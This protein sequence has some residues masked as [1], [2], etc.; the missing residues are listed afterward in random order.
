MNMNWPKRV[1]LVRH[2]ESEGNIK[3]PNDISFNNKANHEFVLTD[4][5]KQQALIAGKYLREKYG[6]FDSYF[7]STFRRTQETLSLLYPEVSP[8][9]D[10]RLNE[11]WRG[12]WHT[13]S[14]EKILTLYPEEHLIRKREG[15]YHYRP[16]GGQSCQDVELMIHSFIQS[17]GSDYLD[18]TVL[19]SAHGKWMLLF[20]RIILNRHPREVESRFKES[21]YK[22]C[23]IVTYESD[24]KTLNLVGEKVLS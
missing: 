6:E 15:E 8:I 20:W 5:G 19:I 16:P 22:N 24:G 12:I 7:C 1:V 14:P 13:M 4:K 23:T 11:W 3:S 21:G 17:L 18:K 2:G 9:V 10:S